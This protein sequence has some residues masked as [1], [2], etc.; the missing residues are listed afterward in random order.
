MDY[1]NLGPAGVKVSPLCLGTMMFGAWGNT[2]Q[3]DCIR[4]IHAA[5]DGGLN[6]IDTAN[7][8]ADGESERIVGRALAGRRDDVVLA[9]KVYFPMGDGPN[10]GGL[11]RKAIQ[12]H[13]EASLQR[14]QT[15]V[16]DLY[17]IHR[18]DPSVPWEETL[19]TLDDLVRQGKVRYL[20]CST[21]HYDVGH[22]PRLAAWQIV[23]TLWISDANGWERFV[24]LQPPYSMLRRTMELEH[25]PMALE[26]GLAAIVWSPLEGGWLTGKYRFE[27]D[28]DEGSPR[29]ERWI[30]NLSDPKFERRSRAVEKLAGHAEKKGASLTHLALAWTLD[31][32]AVTSTIIG[33]RTMEQLTDC[34]GCLE[35]A[36]DDDDRAAVDR[37]VAPGQSVL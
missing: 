30:K 8:Y 2:D 28:L 5:L 14:L 31:N 1:R 11:S 6:F 24:C 23:E 32:P 22:V 37:I 27:G 36:L 10:A 25:F 21:N 13:V 19:G 33:P 4:I 20:G 16:I 7:M 12:Q 18:P 29:A 26:L 17:Q 15:D 35:V 9:T 34:L 3:S